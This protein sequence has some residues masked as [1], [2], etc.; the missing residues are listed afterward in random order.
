MREAVARVLNGQKRV[1]RLPPAPGKGSARNTPSPP[2][3]QVV[4]PDA[5][6]PLNHFFNLYQI[7]RLQSIVPIGAK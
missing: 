7:A 5:V 6:S 1:N 4:P 3:E 2:T